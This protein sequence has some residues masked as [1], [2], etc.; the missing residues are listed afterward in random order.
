MPHPDDRLIRLE[1]YLG[2]P[3]RSGD[4]AVTADRRKRQELGRTAQAPPSS[5][6][7]GILPHAG[8]ARRATLEEAVPGYAVRVPERGSAYKVIT[9][10]QEGKDGDLLRDSFTVAFS[11][12]ETSL[13]QRLHARCGAT[14]LAEEVLFFDLESAGLGQTP[15]FLI[16]ALSWEGGNLVVRQFLARDCREEA[17]VLQLFVDM[18]VEKRLLISFN[19]KSFDLPMVYQRA[20]LH[21][22]PCVLHAY[23]FDLLHECRRVWRKQLPNCQLQTLE[24]YVCGHSPRSDDI[25]SE[26]IP[27]GYEAF[28]RNGNALPLAPILRHNLQDLVTM[29]ELLTKLPPLESI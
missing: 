16:G 6:A 13:Q 22:V 20:E 7:A 29:A 9:P 10:V 27:A 11:S 17:A 24:Q 28:L 2:G 8:S 12:P 18:A 1:R 3:L 21:S 26:L 14:A 15:I 19:G 23:H 4:N 25:P 5:S